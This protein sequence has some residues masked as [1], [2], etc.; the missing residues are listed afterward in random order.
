M[1]Y[2]AKEIQDEW[3]GTLK[4]LAKDFAKE[5][6]KGNKKLQELTKIRNSKIKKKEKKK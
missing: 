6:V 3:Y 4:E 1:K 5:G 2:T